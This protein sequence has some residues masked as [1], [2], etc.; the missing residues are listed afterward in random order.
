MERVNGEESVIHQAY[1]MIQGY[2]ITL[3]PEVR[4]TNHIS[5][6]EVYL[7]FL[8]IYK[9]AVENKI[10]D[11]RGKKNIIT[12]YLTKLNILKETSNTNQELKHR[13][14]NLEPRTKQTKQTNQKT[15]KQTNKQKTIHFQVH[16]K[17]EALQKELKRLR[18]C[19]RRSLMERPT[20]IRKLNQ[21][22]QKE[23]EELD[24]ETVKLS[25]QV[26]V[27]DWMSFYFKH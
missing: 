10:Q 17:Y 4:L 6:N 9:A 7:E 19:V 27:G 3:H 2:H 11:A 25:E 26:Q 16:N 23:I 14:E 12:N 13:K 24:A 22:L 18:K 15:E 5:S 20:M 1:S 21:L 8:Y